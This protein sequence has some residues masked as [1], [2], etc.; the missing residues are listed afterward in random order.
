M[1]NGICPKC[2]GTE[3]WLVAPV[4]DQVGDTGPA[5]EQDVYVCTACKFVEIYARDLEK[6]RPSATAVERS[7]GPYR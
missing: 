3:I 7:V 4:S 1:R 5:F 6:L 2:G